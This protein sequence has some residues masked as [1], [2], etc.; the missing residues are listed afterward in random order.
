MDTQH[1]T[2]TSIMMSLAVAAVATPPSQAR[3][4]RSSVAATATRCALLCCR[5]YTPTQGADRLTHSFAKCFDCLC[6]D[7]TRSVPS[8]RHPGEQ[9]MLARALHRPSAPLP[10]VRLTVR[11]ILHCISLRAAVLRHKLMS[12]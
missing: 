2:G 7:L 3:N 5:W 12:S 8:H 6:S 1:M 9:V 10:W 11:L 4:I